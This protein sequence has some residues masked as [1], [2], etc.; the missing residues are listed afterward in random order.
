MPAALAI[1]PPATPEPGTRA[2]SAPVPSAVDT[3][4]LDSS[5]FFVL[6]DPISSKSS[7]RGSFARAHLRDALVVH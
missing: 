5:L 1:P 7:K 2:S 6:D 4:P 3:L